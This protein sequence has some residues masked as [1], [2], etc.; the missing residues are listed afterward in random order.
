MP[1]ISLFMDIF[2]KNTTDRRLT[3]QLLRMLVA[4]SLLASSSYSQASNPID[5]C[6]ELLSSAKSKIQT[7]LRLD[8]PRT[9]LKEPPHYSSSTEPSLIYEDIP[10]AETNRRPEV[11]LSLHKSA[12]EE[13]LALSYLKNKKILDAGCGSD[14]YF[15]KNLIAQGI[16]AYGIDIALLD[17]VTSTRLSKQ[18]MLHT[19]FNDEEFDVV[20]STYSLYSYLSFLRFENGAAQ[21]LFDNGLKELSRITR[22]GGVILLADISTKHINL[23]ELLKNTQSLKLIS[24]TTNELSR[25]AIILKRIK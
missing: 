14:G 4:L 12:G 5:Y 7:A 21:I 6:A 18:D 23:T 2:M 17:S 24:E 10:F 13:Y 3:A 15:V 20:I 19:S 8:L 11:I 9:V 22:V 16:D 25:K 1:K